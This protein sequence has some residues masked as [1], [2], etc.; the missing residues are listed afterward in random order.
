VVRIERFLFS[1]DVQCLLFLDLT[2]PLADH[3][4]N[5]PKTSLRLSGTKLKTGRV[6][7]STNTSLCT[8][9]A[10]AAA[11]METQ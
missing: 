4:V 8:S 1:P 2:F 7:P 5:R 3:S 11:G 6:P 10:D 9:R